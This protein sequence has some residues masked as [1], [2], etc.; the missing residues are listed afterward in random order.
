MPEDNVIFVGNKPVMNYVLAAVTQFNE[1]AK[2]V[3]IK[4]RGRAISRA[5]DTAE[6]V[7]HRFLTDVQIDRI[8][9]STEE[10]DSEKGEKINVSSIEIFLKRPQTSQ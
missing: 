1:G 9:I 2:E 6:V 8:Q 5:V 3:T 10:L 4:A 7:R